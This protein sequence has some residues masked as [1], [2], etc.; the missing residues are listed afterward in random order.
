MDKSAFQADTRYTITRRENSGKLRPANIY[1]YRLY[2]AFMIARLTEQDGF[3]YKI[4][5]GDIVKIVSVQPVA[6]QDRFA[7]PAAVLDEKTWQD[8][9]VM[10][11][12]ST[13]PH[14]GK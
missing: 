12:Y 2:D 5:Y 11:R 14:T 4:P 6:R 13:A 10:T 9:T 8:R 3:L 7:I 1:V